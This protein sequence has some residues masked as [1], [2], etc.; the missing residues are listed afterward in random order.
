MG[1]YPLTMAESKPYKPT[2]VK[3]KVI[4][5]K[6]MSMHNKAEVPVLKRHDAKHHINYFRLSI[7]FHQKTNIFF[8]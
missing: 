7:S 8:D 6:E 2:A 5:F 1:L 3:Q 4:K